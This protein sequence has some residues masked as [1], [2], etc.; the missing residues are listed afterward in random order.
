[1]G[2]RPMAVSIVAMSGMT[3]S[4]MTW[5]DALPRYS[6]PNVMYISRNI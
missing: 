5:I 6:P 2:S 1:M 3:M 4:A